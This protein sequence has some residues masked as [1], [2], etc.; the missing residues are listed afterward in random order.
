VLVGPND[1]GKSALLRAMH[2][3]LGATTAALYAQLSPDDWREAS[4]PLAIEAELREFNDSDR[5]LFPDEISVADD[6]TESLVVR[7]EATID[8]GG[9]ISIRRWA[10]DGGHQ[11]QL[12]RDQVAGLGWRMVGARSNERDLGA[13]RNSALEKIIESID[14]GQEQEAFD[15]L[16]ATFQ[17]QLSKSDA[18]GVLRQDLADQL[19]KAL[20]SAVAKSDLAFVS[21]SAAAD[22]L[23]DVELHVK[24]PKGMQNVAEQSDGARAMFAIALYD[25]VS[26]A[27]NIVAIDEPET[28]LHPTSQRSLARLLKTSN[29]QKVLA[30][31]ST[32]IVGAFDPDEVIAIKPGG[33]V[34]QPSSGFF[35]DDE[36]M[37]LRWWMRDKLEPLTA[38][39][40]V[41]VEG[42]SDRIVLEAAAECTGRPPARY[43]ACVVETNGAG[44]MGAVF[45]L[46]GPDGFDVRLA[47]L[48]D[49][50]ARAATALKLGVSANEVEKHNV[51][52]S[53]R[54]LEQEYVA[55]VGAET[56]WTAI[57]QSKLFS[58]N[59]LA[60]CPA[61]GESGRRTED[62]VAAF[63]RLKNTYKTR[64]AIV[65]AKLLRKETAKRI[66]SIEGLLTALSS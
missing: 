7:M 30:T 41:A 17:K 32:D 64:A 43:G 9:T 15:K 53:Q 13:S 49:E 36:R 59:E 47:L 22:A 1:V 39:A 37:S 60:N 56:L 63:C 48:I 46:F 45:K 58:K 5:G 27:A 11:R 10:P 29:N 16:L 19:T 18:L 57:E 24:G 61:S 51:W 34:V 28:H 25:L 66:T 20:P 62:D 14:L 12:S 38:A 52:I 65:V 50:D 26:E 21:R 40:V 33:F 54:D 42:I 44:D 6:G 8:D 2:M 31:H 35:S 55:A 3:L 23:K 4:A